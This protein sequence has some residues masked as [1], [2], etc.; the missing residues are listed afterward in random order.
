[1]H[2]ILSHWG[3]GFTFYGVMAFTPSTPAMAVATVTITF[4][5]IFQVFL[6]IFIMF[7]V[8][9]VYNSFPTSKHGH[10]FTH[11]SGSIT[12]F[13]FRSGLRSRCPQT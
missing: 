1:M 10:T 5:M 7:N 2:R 8:L 3:S 4:R 12:P 9:I 11:S 6:L 13:P